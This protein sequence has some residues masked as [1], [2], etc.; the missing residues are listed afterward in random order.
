VLMAYNPTCVILFCLKPLFFHSL[1]KELRF[2]D[3]AGA[4]DPGIQ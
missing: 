1:K 3:N 2:S 4:E